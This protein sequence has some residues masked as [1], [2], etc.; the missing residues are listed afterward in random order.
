M[1]TSIPIPASRWLKLMAVALAAFGLLWQFSWKLAY[2]RSPSTWVCLY[3]TDG[4]WTG[5]LKNESENEPA[6][7]EGTI[8]FIWRIEQ[9]GFWAPTSTNNGMVIWT[10][11]HN[12]ALASFG[13]PGLTSPE[14]LGSALTN[15]PALSSALEAARQALDSDSNARFT[16]AQSQSM[17][18]I[19][20]RPLGY[21]ENA[22]AIVM[23]GVLLYGTVCFLRW[24][25]RNLFIISKVDPTICPECGYSL[26]GLPPSLPPGPAP[27]CP[28]CGHGS[29]IA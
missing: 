23:L 25:I 9:R 15:N 19:R 20:A 1:A 28:E 24:F 21:L 3:Q 11:L 2:R 13:P 4:V 7:F 10:K 29:D 16:R 18:Q 26:I 14:E 5:K 22:L 12:N 17:R 27:T 8:R 6:E